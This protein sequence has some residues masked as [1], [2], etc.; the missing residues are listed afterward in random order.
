MAHREDVI[1]LAGLLEGEGCFLVHPD[2][3]TPGSRSN[4]RVALQMTDHDVVDRAYSVFPIGG[5]GPR[6]VS[7]ANSGGHLGKK[8]H[9][10]VYW[11]A[12]NAEIV[13]R[14]VLPFMGKRR[15]AKILECLNT[16]NLSYHRKG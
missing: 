11:H 3:R 8:P 15:S 10:C 14:A 1:W 16:P 6:E 13:M 9:W 4:L 5:S 2:R 12:A 7:A